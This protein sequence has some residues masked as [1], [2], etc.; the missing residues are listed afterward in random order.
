M[1]VQYIKIIIILSRRISRIGNIYNLYI[2]PI[3][4]FLYRIE[5]CYSFN[6]HNRSNVEKCVG[7]ICK[8]YIM[9]IKIGLL[10][11]NHVYNLPNNFSYPCILNN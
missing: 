4:F 2:L 7:T 5:I 11:V 6:E 3:T 9:P 8:C 10:Q 1:S